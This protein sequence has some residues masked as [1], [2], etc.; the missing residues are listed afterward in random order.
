MKPRHYAL[1]ALAAVLL[2]NN[3]TADLQIQNQLGNDLQ[4][5]QNN[6]VGNF[7]VTASNETVEVTDIVTN[8][9]PFTATYSPSSFT[10][11]NGSR[12]VETGISV[13]SDFPAG[14]V[15]GEAIFVVSNRSNIQKPVDFEVVENRNWTITDSTFKENVS[16]GNGGKLGEIQFENNGNTRVD[17]QVNQSGKL[18]EFLGLESTTLYRGTSDTYFVNYDIPRSTEFG[19][20]N[21]SITFY[22]ETGNDSRTLNLSTRFLDK[23]PPELVAKQ[24]ENFSAT[25]PSTFKIDA[26]DNIEVNQVNAEVLYET[27]V[28]R[29]NSTVTVNQSLETIEFDRQ[30]DTTVWNGEMQ[31]NDRVG[32]YYI[33]GS[34]TD[35]AGNTVYFTDRYS[36]NQ[37]DV[38]TTQGNVELPAY[39]YDTE[40][41]YPVGNIERDT[42]LTV[43]LESFNQPLGDDSS[44][45]SWS[46]GVKTPSGKEYFSQVNSSV[47]LEQ[48][49]EINLFVYS[50]TPERFQGELDYKPIDEHTGLNKTTFYG[51]FT[52]YTSPKDRE[53]V[54]YNK[55]YRCDGHSSQLLNN[56]YWNCRFNISANTVP[57]QSE[58]GEAVQFVI[59]Q[60]VK[61]EQEEQWQTRIDE[62]KQEKN[63]AQNT[64]AWALRILFIG[65]VAGLYGFRYYPRHYG[66]YIKAT[67]RTQQA[68]KSLKEILQEKFGDKIPSISIR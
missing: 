19:Y 10:V 56:S 58:L 8:G 13:P 46:I 32:D 59:P 18:T 44:G 54:L 12:N 2:L 65:L 27:Q 5:G 30:E 57:P 38:I 53:F 21:A 39:K 48:A 34:I 4:P 17:L 35:G 1:S 66:C 16:V 55:V 3:A 29:N 26:T 60:Q 43:T 47:T 22:T 7:T 37:L 62:A 20:Y 52:N 41:T 36:V 67:S 14:N 45:E 23:I 40:F 9:L 28:Q 15:S 68:R 31:N 61:E 64:S 50:D 25:K 49:G 33:N 11:D 24:F 42:D 51:R 63:N 6:A